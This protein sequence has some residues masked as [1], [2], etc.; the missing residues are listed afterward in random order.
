[1]DGSQY[2]AGYST[3]LRPMVQLDGGRF[4]ASDLN[5]LTAGLSTGTIVCLF[6]RTQCTRYH[7]SNE[8]ACQEAVDA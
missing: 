4:A 6:A 7:R 3:D 1:M 8:K 2:P 5:D